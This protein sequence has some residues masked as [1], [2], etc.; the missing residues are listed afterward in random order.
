MKLYQVDAFTARR[1]HGNPAAVVP[2][3]VWP[4]EDHVLQ[5]IAA[6]NNLSETAFFAKRS[7]AE[8]GEPC[9]FLLRWFTP[10]A[11]AAL[12]GH[13]TLATAHVLW[14]ELGFSNDTIRFD[15]KYKGLLKV[16]RKGS[17]IELDFPELALEQT[18]ITSDLVRALGREPV[19]VYSGMYTVC[20]FD[21]KR[22]V[23]EINPDLHALKAL[24]DVRALAVTA[25][26]A[27]HDY[28]CRLFAPRL[29]INED[30]FTGSLQCMLAPYWGKKLGKSEVTAHQ[31]SSRGG[32]AT[33]RLNDPEGRVKIAGSCVTY[34]RGEIE[35]SEH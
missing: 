12:C 20:V 34:L 21:N 16:S 23:H 9:D 29:G 15:S 17:Q 24:E 28:V 33:C 30:P 10:A 1:F 22:Q 14:T 19:E 5:M 35:I 8:S 27:G 2:L 3:E 4:P 25:P 31:V 6:E 18:E 13:A 7:E 26:G 32:E 11:E